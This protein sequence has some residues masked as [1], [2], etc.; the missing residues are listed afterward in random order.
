MKALRL[1]FVD[2]GLVQVTL[3]LTIKVLEIVHK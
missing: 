2:V 1:I 3:G